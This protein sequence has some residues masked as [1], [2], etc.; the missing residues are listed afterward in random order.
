[1]PF[2]PGENPN[3][4]VLGSTIKVGPI[5]E[6]D[7]IHLIKQ[8]LSNQPRNLCLFTLGINT[9]YRASELL[10]IR[11]DQVSHLRAGD[12]LEIKQRKTNTLRT[13]AVNAT[14]V[15]AI[16]NWL[17]AHPNPEANSP[18]F[19]GL[20]GNCLRVSSV[21]HLVKHWCEAAKSKGNYGSHSLRKTWGFHQRVTKGSSLPLIMKAFG[22]KS[23]QQT[24]DYLGILSEEIMALYE[25]EL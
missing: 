14:A 3:H 5:R 22:H 15:S 1:M 2:S 6:L 9:A 19:V 21:C 7:A 17:S 11:V 23:E 20:R 12:L 16:D 4:P 13:V 18:L 24:L 10:S 25:M 8:L